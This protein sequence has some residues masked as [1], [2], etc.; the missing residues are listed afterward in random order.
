MSREKAS[1]MRKIDLILIALR[2]KTGAKND[3][4]MCEILEIP[5][6]TLSRWKSEDSIPPKKLFEFMEKYGVDIS[7]SFNK[8]GNN[9]NLN[10]GD[11][12][13][14]NINSNLKAKNAEI[15]EIVELL[16]NYSTPKLLAEIKEKLLKIKAVME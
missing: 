3:K 11:G 5:Y 14:Q 15:A 7:N 2:E 12:A 10:V 4:E 6:P 9:S 16:N 1:K 13:N 8:V